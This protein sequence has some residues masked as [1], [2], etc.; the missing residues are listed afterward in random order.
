MSAATA[1][2]LGEAGITAPVV[3]V[4]ATIVAL[5]DRVRQ[6]ETPAPTAPRV[7]GARAGARRSELDAPPDPQ[8]VARDAQIVEAWRRGEIPGR[9]APG[10]VR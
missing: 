3:V 2:V 1:A 10:G 6:S 8:T 9:H 4:F 5:L 7:R